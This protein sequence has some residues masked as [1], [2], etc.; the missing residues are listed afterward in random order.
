MRDG[1][2]A[3]RQTVEVFRCPTCGGALDDRVDDFVC[4]ECGR[5][6]TVRGGVPRF[7]EDIDGSLAQIQK[8]FDFEHRRYYESQFTRFRPELVESFLADCELDS[9]FFKDLAAL[10]AGCGS[11][12]WTYAL[13]ELGADVTGIDL[14]AGGI[15]V[16]HQAL[17]D[18]P[19]V[20]LAQANVFELPFAPATFGFVM[21]WGVLHHTPSTYD[22]FSRL[23]PLVRPGGTLYVMV[24]EQTSRI[25]ELGTDILRAALRRMSPERRYRFCRHLIFRNPRIAFL[26]GRLLL[27]EHHTEDSP[28]E[29]SSVQ[30]GLY[31]AYSPRYNHLHT[32]D[33]VVG[34]FA[35]SGFTDITVIDSAP[36]AVKVRGVRSDPLSA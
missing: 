25:R 9:G 4:V 28:V 7:V 19:N 31:D 18:R 30:F 1:S 6:T 3:L 14:T 13:A 11:G 8:A 10:D 29:F 17:G 33:E 12:R 36:G 2:E 26:L 5:R 24:Y 16:A 35:R 32:R 15:E 23:A 22:A 27:V 21:S 34:W 20:R